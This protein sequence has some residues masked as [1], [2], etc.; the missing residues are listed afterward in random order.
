MLLLLGDEWKFAG[1][2]GEFTSGLAEA[3]AAAA[4]TAAAAAMAAASVVAAS[5]TRGCPEEG[6]AAGAAGM[7][8]CED[9]G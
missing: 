1:T 2:E 7:E 6:G 4:A 8:S 3:E 5:G 9:S